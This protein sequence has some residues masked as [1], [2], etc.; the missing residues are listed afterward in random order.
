MKKIHILF[1]AV[2]FICSVAEAQLSYPQCDEAECSM[3]GP[4]NCAVY[5]SLSPEEQAFVDKLDEL[6]ASRNL[7]FLTLVDQLVTDSRRWSQHMSRVKRLYHGASFENCARGRDDGDGVF[8]MW[9][10][11]PGHNAKLLNA[12]D[13]FMGVGAEGVWW[14]YRALSSMDA[15]VP[16]RNPESDLIKAED[17]ETV[18]PEYKVVYRRVSGPLGIFERKVAVRVPVE[19]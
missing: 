10:S 9:R 8:R 11:S 1:I 17:Q 4:R 14:T 2:F 3:D 13:R 7:P 5:M 12:N 15:Y 19:N 6:R 18:Q 16:G